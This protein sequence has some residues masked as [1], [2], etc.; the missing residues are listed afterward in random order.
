M[1]VTMDTI[2]KSI[3]IN[4]PIQKVWRAL[5]DM[6]E[7][8][9]W[10]AGPAVMDAAEGTEF[11]FWGGKIHGTVTNVVPEE[12]LDLEWYGGDW[13]NPS[14]VTFTLTDEDDATRLDVIHEGFPTNE[15]I[16]IDE[17]W[18]GDFLEPLK[19]YIESSDQSDLLA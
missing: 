11:Q 2:S 18:E 4:A 16:H 5:T 1:I 6:H 3:Y 7:I 19:G 10:G 12:L 9:G 13:S 14:T 15:Y 8:E 17:S